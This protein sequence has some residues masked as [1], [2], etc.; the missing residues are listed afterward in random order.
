MSKKGEGTFSE[1]LKAQS[2]KDGKYVAIKCMKK[3]FDTL[4]Q[5]GQTADM[6][7]HLRAGPTVIQHSL[8]SLAV[9]S[10]FRST[11]CREVQALRRLAPHP[12]IVRL[13]EVLLCAL[14]CHRLNV[15]R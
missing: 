11:L 14:L 15:K 3:H 8:T 9:R 13:L 1:V 10:A 12:N 4:E 7:Q 2:V 5:V 6:L